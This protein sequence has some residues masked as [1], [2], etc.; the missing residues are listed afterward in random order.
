VSLK[1]NGEFI[2]TSDKV[3]VSLSGFLPEKFSITGTDKTKLNEQPPED[4]LGARKKDSEGNIIE[5][6]ETFVAF[7]VSASTTEK[8]NFVGSLRGNTPFVFKADVCYNYNTEALSELCVLD[9]MIDIADDAICNPSGSK[10]VFSSASPIGVTA[11]RQ[12]VAGLNKIQFSF[13]IVHS[14]SGDV[15]KKTDFSANVKHCPRSASN[16]RQNEDQVVVTV[17]TGL[18]VVT[19]SPTA[20]AP[21][22]CN[23]LSGGTDATDKSESSGF[24]KLV[25]G[26]RTVTCTQDL[27]ASR[28]DFQRRVDITLD[29]DYFD[30][31]DKKVLVKS[32]GVGG[33]GVVTPATAPVAVV[34]GAEE[35]KSCQNRAAVLNDIDKDNAKP[36]EDYLCK[37][38]NIDKTC[39]AADPKIQI[40]WAFVSDGDC[41]NDLEKCYRSTSK[42]SCAS[43]CDPATGECNSP[44]DVEP[45]GSF[46]SIAVECKTN[47][48]NCND[49][50]DDP[51]F[52]IRDLIEG[53][54][55]DKYTFIIDIA[56]GNFIKNNIGK[57]N[58]IILGDSPKSVDQPFGDNDFLTFVDELEK[59][60]YTEGARNLLATAYVISNAPP[61]FCIWI[62]NCILL[63]DASCSILVTATGAPW[64]SNVRL[65]I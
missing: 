42:F 9:N 44:P 14:G 3:K 59:H 46:L 47:S 48:K 50:D 41:G 10:S 4:D 52:V 62:L 38:Q 35:D 53:L 60:V 39:S 23:G 33:V 61:T 37:N 2:L 12:S 7:P 8:F 16:R 55:D 30:S 65:P 25:N 18:P 27:E 22:K 20:I 31:V 29:F 51:A 34:G 63:V 24:V 6:V 40:T 26:R 56:D 15:F 28:P 19:T 43:G 13:D 57:Y 49:L 5:P 32:L 54:T 1:N 64:L 45:I 17:N 36:D 21:L 58:L 11:F